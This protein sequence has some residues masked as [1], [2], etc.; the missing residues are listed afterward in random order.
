MEKFEVERESSELLPVPVPFVFVTPSGASVDL[1]LYNKEIIK[2]A[3]AILVEILEKE[4]RG[5]FLHF[6]ERLISELRA[7]K[8]TDE[9]IERVGTS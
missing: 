6:R 3:L 2:K 9:E 8:K 1:R 5:W 4:S 7:Q